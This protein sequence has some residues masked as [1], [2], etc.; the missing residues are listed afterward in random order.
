MKKRDLIL[1]LCTIGIILIS[2][3][4]ISILPEKENAILQI[5]VGDEIYGEYSLDKNQSI[6]INDTN[7]CII[8]NGKVRM[9]EANCPDHVCIHSKEIDKKG[10]T[11]ICMPN[12]IVLEII[13]DEKELDG[14]AS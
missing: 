10:G 8:E 4:G 1:I 5:R 2:F 9:I 7:V 3:I 11:I 13:S 14:I 6:S 12:Q